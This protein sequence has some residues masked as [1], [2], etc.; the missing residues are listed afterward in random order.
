MGDGQQMIKNMLWIIATMVVSIGLLCS[1]CGN[2]NTTVKA[3]PTATPA[4]TETTINEI[5]P[6][7][8]DAGQIIIT[9]E[10]NFDPTSISGYVVGEQEN[11]QVQRTSDGTYYIDGVPEGEHDIIIT[12]T[13]I[14][15]SLTQ[16]PPALTAQATHGIRINDI[17]VSK[18]QR[19]SQANLSLPALGSV[20]GVVTLQNQSDHAG[21]MVYIPGTS[22]LAM[23][24]TSGQYSIT[25]VPQGVHNLYFERDGF[26][27]GQMEELSFQGG[28]TNA[29]SAIKLLLS[30]GAT[31][32]LVLAGGSSTTTTRNI[33]VNIVASSDAVL[34]RLSENS[35]FVGVDWQP[36]STQTTFTFA[37]DGLRTLF[38]QLANANGLE[39]APYEASITVDL[40]PASISLALA[41]TT[42]GGSNGR[43]VQ[44]TCSIPATAAEMQVATSADFAGATWVSP[45]ASFSVELPA[46]GSQVVYV[47]FRDVASSGFAGTPYQYALIAAGGEVASDIHLAFS[48]SP[49]LSSLCALS[50]AGT[51]TFRTGV[52]LHTSS[53]STT[54]TVGENLGLG[55]GNASGVY[56]RLNTSALTDALDFTLRW[57]VTG[58]QGNITSYKDLN[59]EVTRTEFWGLATPIR[60]LND[61]S[62]LTI[63]VPGLQGAL[64]PNHCSEVPR[65]SL[66][67][68]ATYSCVVTE[69]GQVKCWGDLPLTE[70]QYPTLTTP[71]LAIAVAAGTNHVCHLTAAGG[72]AC[73]GSNTSGELGNQGVTASA[74]PT[75]VVYEA[76]S[77]PELEYIEAITVGYNHTCGLDG[78][79]GILCWGKNESGEI[80][81]LD[82]NIGSGYP[83]AQFVHGINGTTGQ[84]AISVAAGGIH[85]C[86]VMTSGR[87]KCWGDNLAG[88]LGIDMATTFRS[89]PGADVTGFDGSSG[90]TATAIATGYTHTCAITDTGGV[91][92][93]G[94]GTDGQLGNGSNSA[95][96]STPVEVSGIGSTT[97][98]GAVNLCAGLAHACALIEDGTVRC[99]GQGSSGQLGNAGTTASNTPVNVAGISGVAGNR[100]VAVGCFENHSCAVTDTGAVKCWGA[101]GSGQLGDGGT[102]NQSSPVAAQ[103]PDSSPFADANRM[104]E[105]ISLSLSP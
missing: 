30:T 62:P 42:L 64:P 1:A 95:T 94:A 63:S 21:V 72:V 47:R 69:S 43:T 67:L 97:D 102:T 86:A 12:G 83:T 96:A 6:I 99:W 38:V 24:D 23:S 68:G 80:G 45:Q 74:T 82:A 41:S 90:N 98:N 89:T 18:G 3:N 17:L 37:G 87:V 9:V 7:S 4:P 57:M 44:M 22:Y 53:A 52:T 56:Y 71:S 26:H 79:G 48:G 15:A 27:R 91:R 92:C 61:L 50:Q 40:F 32:N 11:L 54:P 35:T 60:A 101:N 34:M 84:Q 25:D 77:Y 49:F 55:S 33:T 58:D 76:D 13:M 65:A 100:A 104:N 105:K 81:R 16:P 19:I 103:N 31:G 8:S 73:W 5:P 46:L 2:D 20:S 85:T 59:F 10:P 39:S 93:W 75:A 88:Q 36:L 78:Y 66:A 29:V 28:I 14:I 51:A 70:S